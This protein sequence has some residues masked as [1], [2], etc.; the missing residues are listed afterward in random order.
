MNGDS[1]R[2][3]EIFKK[4]YFVLFEIIIFRAF[5]IEYADWFFIKHQWQGQLA[6]HP[7]FRRLFI[8]LAS[9]GWSRNI[10]GIFNPVRPVFI[11]VNKGYVNNTL[12]FD[13]KTAD[14]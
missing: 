4:I 9:F 14:K 10:Y 1:C 11:L 5:Y 6:F 8:K 12:F 2:K 7:A 13:G 3:S